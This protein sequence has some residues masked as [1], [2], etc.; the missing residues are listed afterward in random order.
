M[1][2]FGALLYFGTV[3]PRLFFRTMGLNIIIVLGINLAFGFTFSGIDN[4][5]HI[6]GLN[7]RIYCDRN[8]SF[9]EEKTTIA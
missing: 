6:G 3:Y 8:G 5:G 1:G 2:L 4:A 9:S 7:W